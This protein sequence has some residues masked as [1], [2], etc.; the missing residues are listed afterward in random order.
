MF[1]SLIQGIKLVGQDGDLLKS[2]DSPGG[3]KDRICIPSHGIPALG[4]DE[5]TTSYITFTNFTFLHNSVGGFPFLHTLSSIYC[6]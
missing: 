3:S 1:G 6:L 4:M 2:L 5:V